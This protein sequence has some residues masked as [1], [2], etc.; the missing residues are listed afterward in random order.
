MVWVAMKY[1]GLR[2]R[3]PT[4]TLLRVFLVASA[5]ILGIAAI[6]LSGVLTN[7]VRHQ[8]L[9]D[10]EESLTEF[11]AAIVRPSLVQ[12]NAIV[13]G[14]KVTWVMKS[15]IAQDPAIVTV[16]VWRSD[17]VL[18]WTNRAPQRIGKKFPIDDHLE[19]ALGGTTVGTI[20]EAEQGEATVERSLGFTRLLQVYAP[21]TAPE[22]NRVVG[23]YEIY[24][25]PEVAE[26]F[27]TH[28]KHMIWIILAGVFGAMYLALAVLV[29][30]ASRMLQRRTTELRQR[31]R[32]LAESYEALE[33]GS[34]E[35]VRMLNAIVEAKDPYTAG[36][37]QRVQR[38]ARLIGDE[39][40]L[41]SD[42][43]D[44]LR[45][46]ALFHDIGKVRVPDA[47]LTK[48]DVLTPAERRIVMDHSADGAEIVAHLSRLRASVPIIRHHHERWDG[49]GYPDGL[50]GEEIPICAAIAG[51]ADAWD[52]MISVR[53]Y[54]EALS[55]EDALDELRAGRGGQFH[56]VVVDAFL[57]AVAVH[58]QALSWVAVTPESI[59]A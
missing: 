33:L 56:P 43:L 10:R 7:S 17:G 34:L 3:V 42:E 29:R 44:A 16:K 32:D 13:V 50:A 15:T 23:A 31:T 46:G 49:R 45:F 39:L 18:A 8:V 54:K 24:A 27:I 59:V 35:A 48:P 30:G 41:P 20:G 5:L 47:I 28:R 51:L 58:P 12:S 11:V 22:T 9:A 4:L 2:P 25:D 57:R 40:R 14:P 37:S 38:V 6:V 21:I 26:S 36:H 19:E 1:P 55:I 52:A 53:P